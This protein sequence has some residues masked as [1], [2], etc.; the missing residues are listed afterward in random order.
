MAVSVSSNNE[1]K[2]GASHQWQ[3]VANLI[4]EPVVLVTGGEE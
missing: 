1:G 3:I 4:A 2:R